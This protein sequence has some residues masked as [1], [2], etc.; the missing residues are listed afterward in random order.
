[1]RSSVHLPQ[2]DGPTNTTN[3]PESIS[4]SMPW[5]TW[6]VAVGLD[7]VLQR[8]FGHASRRAHV[9]RQAAGAYARVP[10][11]VQYSCDDAR[12]REAGVDDEILPRDA[13]RL[14]G[15][16]EQRG[17]GDVVLRQPELEALL[18]DELLLLFRR[19]PQR[20]LP[21]RG[22]RAGND[23]VDADVARAELARERARE[24][25]DRSLCRRVSG[26]PGS[27]PTCTPQW[28][29]LTSGV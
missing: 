6:L 9:P 28:T 15:R 27:S 11:A 13:A 21:L 12:L 5:M 17:P 18:I 1:M 14:V 3:S 19:E 10:V 20:A 4:R 23:P 8:D 16:K 2:P 22:D 7:D 25:V 26:K 29:S 24:P